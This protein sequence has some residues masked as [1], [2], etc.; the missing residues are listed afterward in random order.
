LIRP[1]AEYPFKGPH[2]TIRKL[3]D[4]PGTL[5]MEMDE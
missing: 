2:K 1:I 4:R 3:E 5:Q